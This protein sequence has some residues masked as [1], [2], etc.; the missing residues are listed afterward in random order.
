[1]DA[2]GSLSYTHGNGSDGS[3]AC[4]PLAPPPTCSSAPVCPSFPW[5]ADAAGQ[6]AQGAG[7]AGDPA[8]DPGPQP[9]HYERL[10]PCGAC[11]AS[12]GVGTRLS[13]HDGG[14]RACKQEG[15]R[16]VAGGG[17]AGVCGREGVRMVAGEWQEGKR[18]QVCDLAEC[19]WAPCISR[20]TH[21]QPSSSF[22]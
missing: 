4:V 21:A 1:M 14:P 13:G 10:R 11:P 5:L 8:A 6:W 16:W 9:A 18:W 3:L 2:P 20:Y 22:L 19:S 17:Q 12:G 15:G 7:Q